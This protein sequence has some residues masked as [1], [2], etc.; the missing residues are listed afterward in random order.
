MAAGQVRFTIEAPCQ[1]SWE[2]MAGD[3]R[4]RFCERCRSNVYNLAELTRGE[5]LDLVSSREG[6]VCVRLYA[7]PDGTVVTRRC[8]ARAAVAARR[9]AYELFAGICLI[10]AAVL[11]AWS[12]QVRGVP[13]RVRAPVAPRLVPPSPRSAPPRGHAGLGKVVITADGA[14]R[15]GL[16]L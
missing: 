14:P 4:V 7:R 12:T 10:I 3:E 8:F 2:Q 15:G 1:A 11:G 16:K 6:S 13:W 5:A 9:L